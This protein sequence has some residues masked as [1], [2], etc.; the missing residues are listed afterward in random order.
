MTHLTSHFR[1]KVTTMKLEHTHEV[2]GTKWLVLNEATYL[3]KNGKE[4]KWEYVARR[5]DPK[6]VTLVCRSKQSQRLLFITQP[7]VPLNKTII[8]FP[9]GLVDEGETLA[10]AALR[11]LKEETG[12]TGEV[13][14]MSLETPKSAGLTNET[15]T[16]VEC[17]VDEDR[18]EDTSLEESEDI[19]S[20]WMTP[21]ELVDY[22]ES[23]DK[24][25][26]M[27]SNDVAMYCW[28]YLHTQKLE[29]STKS[30]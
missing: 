15:T 13:V 29:N 1:M 2:A 11:E 3:T 12:Y 17:L 14:S 19:H 26:Y 4:G 30:R 9:A 24:E 10:D 20:F 8:E 5:G 21:G 27:L 25:K 6:V 16:I 7:R 28:G 22:F 18:K 23:I